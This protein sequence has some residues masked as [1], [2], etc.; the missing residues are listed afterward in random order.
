MASTPILTSL[1][2]MVDQIIAFAPTLIAIII[3]LIVGLVVGKA[4]GKI[5][6]K[7]LDKIGLDDLINK[8]IIGDM[9]K[10]TGGHVVDFFDVSI[11]WFIYLIF[12]IVIIDLLNI[13]IVAD[14][15]A[16]LV[17]YIPIILAAMITLIIGLLIVDFLADLV[18]NVV[19]GMGI[20]DKVESTPMGATITASGMK[21]SSI[22]S[23][24]VRVFG[25]LIFIL[26][27]LNILKLT[28]IANLVQDVINY[29]PN[30]FVGLLILIVGLLAIDFFADYIAN[31]MKG[32]SVEH[33]DILVPAFRGILSLVVMLLA[34]DAMLIDT[35]IF[36][37][38][39]G[40]LA[41]GLAVVV[42]F[43]WGIKD[44]IVAYA[45]EKK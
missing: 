40:P 4:I 30:L 32:M 7:F 35:G 2:G 37:L 29:L 26:A 42:A 34:L 31:I 41:W 39:I 44:A 33:A 14:F 5:G 16:S 11:R 17:L 45:R 22:V 15:I 43:K 36:Y 21:T 10:R 24:I 20:D 25:Y 38:F 28:I 19:I 18:R 1:Y 23:G 8:T 6:A 12:A 13:Q 27:A 9:I 3:L